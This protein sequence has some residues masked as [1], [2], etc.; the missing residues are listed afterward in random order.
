MIRMA[1]EDDD[2][3]RLQELSTKFPDITETYTY[4]FGVANRFNYDD[5][6]VARYDGDGWFVSTALVYDE[7]GPQYETAIVHPEYK[8]GQHVIVEIYPDKEAAATGHERWVEVMT[9]DPL[10]DE[11]PDVLWGLIT[12]YKRGA[13]LPW[14]KYL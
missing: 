8:E 2:K 11:L 5:R 12:T 9:S 10:P 6:K 4:K 3:K 13:E 7:E 14:R 1:R